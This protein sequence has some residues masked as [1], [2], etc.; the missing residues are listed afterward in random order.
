MLNN[1]KSLIIGNGPSTKLLLN[2]GFHNIPDDVD[3]YC[4]SNAYKFCEKLNWWPKYYVMGDFKVFLS[5]KEI[6]ENIVN[7][8]SIPVKKFYFGVLT[9][10]PAYKDIKNK[11]KDSLNKVEWVNHISSGY[12]SLNLAIKKKYS[13]IGMIGMDGVYTWFPDKMK[14]L[15]PP[16]YQYGQ[17]MYLET[18]ETHPSYFWPN[19]IEKGDIVR[20]IPEIPK[21]NSASML[22]NIQKLI[23]G[24]KKQNIT[25]YDYC[26]NKLVSNKT[27]N[28]DLVFK[29]ENI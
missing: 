5:K 20:D 8:P 29:K 22:S 27:K 11:F 2:Y 4:T 18:I 1:K 16:L 10:H 14:S 6:F 19:Y 12:M 21:N 9:T 28:L 23:G 7:D 17:A 3:T 25:I 26:D 15:G 24:A 13:L